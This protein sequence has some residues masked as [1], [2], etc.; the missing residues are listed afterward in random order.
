MP[1]TR[2]LERGFNLA[3]G[4]GVESEEKSGEKWGLPSTAAIC[5]WHSHQKQQQQRHFPAYQ[6]TEHTRQSS[7]NKIMINEPDQQTNKARNRQT[8]A[9]CLFCVFLI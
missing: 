6:G 4:G 7:P 1:D 9:L 3:R 2:E 8:F 5:C